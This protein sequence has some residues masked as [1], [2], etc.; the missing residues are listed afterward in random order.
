MFSALCERLGGAERPKETQKVEHVIAIG[1]NPSSIRDGRENNI[2]TKDPKA[3]GF[4]LRENMI[5]APRYKSG[6]VYGEMRRIGKEG[7][8]AAEWHCATVPP[9]C[10]FPPVRAGTATN[11]KLF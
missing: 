11:S 2:Q 1:R 10:L 6:L 4:S 3:T 5:Q 7:F 8:D 9:P